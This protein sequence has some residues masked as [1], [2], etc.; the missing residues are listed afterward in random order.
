M[1]AAPVI[2]AVSGADA[3]VHQFLVHTGQHFD[4]NMSAAF[5]EDLGLDDPDVNL[6]VGSGS[7]SGQTAEIMTAFDSW[8]D[9]RPADLVVVYGD[10]NSTIAAAL[11]AAKRGIQ[12]AHVEAGLRSFDRTMPEEI[13]R[14]VTDHLSDVLLTPSSDADGNLVREGIDEGK[15]HWRRGTTCHSHSECLQVATF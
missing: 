15:I 9:E 7:Q 3:A 6:G 4:R 8:L 11:V 5:F 2:R 10:V 12:V 13:N 14:V 1:K